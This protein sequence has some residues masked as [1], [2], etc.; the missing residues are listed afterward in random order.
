MISSAEPRCGDCTMCC[1]TVGFTGDW[2]IT[3]I[4]DEAEKF[5]I[6]FGAWSTCNKL[7][8]SGC[9]IQENKPRVC[10]EFYCQ[11][12]ERNLSEKHF[13]KDT[14]F[15]TVLDESNPIYIHS[16]DR[17]LPPDIQYN[18]NKQLLNE[19][20]NEISDSLNEEYLLATI[21]T[22]QGNKRIR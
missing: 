12:I 3:D 14:G 10:K 2:K 4:Y 21:R 19:M 7:C 9:S 6:D 22:K 15:V 18:N 5:D 11:Y 13:P 16:V 8:D 17:T 1:Q 20:I